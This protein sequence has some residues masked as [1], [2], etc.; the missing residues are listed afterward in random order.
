MATLQDLTTD[1]NDQNKRKRDEND[2]DDEAVIVGV[3]PGTNFS[4]SETGSPRRSSVYLVFAE[5]GHPYGHESK[6]TKRLMQ[7]VF[8]NVEDAN[9]RAR[10]LA[11]V[12]K[13]DGNHEVKEEENKDKD[14]KH[15][16]EFTISEFPFRWEDHD[17]CEGFLCRRVF[18]AMERIQYEY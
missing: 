2:S 7:G 9:R 17:D 4:T 18:V 12:E 14:E 5:W 15:A 6:E 8:A 16:D 11:G 3:K 13:C 10:I 1:D